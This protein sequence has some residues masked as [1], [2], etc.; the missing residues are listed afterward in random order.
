M[1]APLA[2]YLG[3]S[4]PWAVLLAGA[5]IFVIVLCFAEVGSRFDQAGGPYLYAR[6]AFGSA[7]GF[8]VGWLHILTR[9]LSGA[10]V[11]NVLVSYLA[12]L[13]PAAGT[14][15]GRTI[16]MT[17]ATLFVTAVNLGGVRQAAWTVSLFTVAK[18]LPLL[19]LIAIG[20]FKL[21]GD[22]LAAQTVSEPKWT[23]AILLL[24]FAYGGFESGIIAASE[25]RDPKRHTAFALIAAMLSVTAIYCL[26]Q[27]VVV[28]V[29]PNAASNTVPVAATLRELLGPVGSTVG[30]LAVV[31]SVYGWLTG[32]A[33]MTPR[34]MFSMAER[35]ELPAFLA[36]VHPRWRTPHNA[37]VVNS[38][39]AL[40][41]GLAGSFAQMATFSVIS[42]IAIY[43][44]TCGALIALRR[45]QGDV[46]EFRVPGGYA[47]ALSG[48][49]F[50]VWLFATRSLAQA[51]FLPVV[52]AVGAAL[53]LIAR[54]RGEN[55]E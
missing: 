22:V 4:S 16:T 24:V 38:A 6:E 8:Q 1:P 51:W 44:T 21:N 23:D 50:C 33:L 17:V 36:R 27:L 30:S 13:A 3:A 5:G 35:G 29:L 41:L 2:G 32:F 46:S 14:P 40:A 9:M 12:A 31:I 7:A 28:A 47:V 53:W 10:A 37:I 48:I 25:T 49:A 11:L 45:R 26:L 34:L 55:D 42:R 52:M 54:R 43:A 39:I 19:G 15:L 18:L 20:M